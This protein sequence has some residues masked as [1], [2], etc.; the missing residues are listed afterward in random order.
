MVSLCERV[1]K[2]NVKKKNPTKQKSVK[3][4]KAPNSFENTYIPWE[5]YC[6][7]KTEAIHCS[8][9]TALNT[10]SAKRNSIPR[11][12]HF[13]GSVQ[14]QPFSSTGSRSWP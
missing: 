4:H 3:N 8:Q 5:I 6:T 11:D 2:G 14:Q 7:D 13:R 9:E 10:K 1:Q 12:R